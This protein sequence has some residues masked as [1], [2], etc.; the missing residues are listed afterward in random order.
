MEQRQ[1]FEAAPRRAVGAWMRWSSRNGQ[2]GMS[3]SSVQSALPPPVN[4]D[5]DSSASPPRCSPPLARFQAEVRW[6]QQR[7][8]AT[9]NRRKLAGRL[10]DGHPNKTRSAWLSRRP[11]PDRVCD[12][13]D[14][15]S[16]PLRSSQPTTPRP[17]LS[18]QA[19][20]PLSDNGSHCNVG[21]KGKTRQNE[22]VRAAPSRAALPLPL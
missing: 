3:R 5:M 20:A 7:S 8:N 11:S 9:T 19:E 14:E 10:L 12:E 17:S 2:V 18:E 1:S 15:G 16:E 4:R 21:K 6:N 22:A 13:D